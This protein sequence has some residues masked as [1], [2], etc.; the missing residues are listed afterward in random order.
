[1]HSAWLQNFWHRVRRGDPAALG[2]LGVALLALVVIIWALTNRTAGVPQIPEAISRGQGAE[3]QLKV[4]FHDIEEIRELKI[5][6]YLLGVVAAEMEP[7]WP[8]EALKAQAIIARTFT[9]QRV[10]EFGTL[11]DRPNAHASTDPEEFQAYDFSRV[12]E[13]IRTAIKE[14]RGEIIAHRNEFARTWFHAYSG[15]QTTTPEV[16]L[17]LPDGDQPYIK[18]VDDSDLDGEVPDD[19][20]HWELHVTGDKLRAAVQEAGAGDPG[21]IEKVTVEDWSSDGR[22]LTI[23]VNAVEVNAVALRMALGSTEFRS[24]MITNIEV[25]DG[26][27]FHGKGYGHGVGMS[28]WGAKILADRGE[29]AEAIIERYYNPVKLVRLWD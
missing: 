6:D 8:I 7:S 17:A 25:G 24:T 5:E 26:V 9:L 29:K 15:G 27:L 19:V 1:M 2:I 18:P 23:A 28:Q 20:K 16:G 4:Y 3:P 12:T 14:T 21:P 11:P 13:N 22:A 10:S